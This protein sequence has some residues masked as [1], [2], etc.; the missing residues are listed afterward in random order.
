MSGRRWVCS[1][2]DEVAVFTLRET[3][4]VSAGCCMEEL[5]TDEVCCSASF[6]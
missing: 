1:S 2:G 3:R 6:T 5:S 4:R